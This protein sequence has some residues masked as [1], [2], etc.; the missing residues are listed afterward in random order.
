M[1]RSNAGI[2]GAWWGARTTAAWKRGSPTTSPPS[3]CRPPLP[4]RKGDRSTDDFGFRAAEDKVYVNDLHASLTYFFQGRNS[5]LT[6]VGGEFNL[7]ARL[8]SA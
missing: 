7:A 6:D 8:R 5:R 3:A 4:R 1:T 2:A